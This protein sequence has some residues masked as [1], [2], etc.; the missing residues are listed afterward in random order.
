VGINLT[1]VGRLPAP[2]ELGIELPKPDST[3]Y[4]ICAFLDD[5]Q[6]EW[7]IDQRWTF[8]RQLCLATRAGVRFY[9]DIGSRELESVRLDR[10]TLAGH[11]S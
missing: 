7:E 10:E 1:L 5:A 3:P 2:A 6:I 9:F 11:A 8:D 4:D